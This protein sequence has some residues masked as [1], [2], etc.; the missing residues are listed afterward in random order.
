MGRGEVN[1]LHIEDKHICLQLSSS[2]KSTVGARQEKGWRRDFLTIRHSYQ[3][4]PLS[5]SALRKEAFATPL[6]I[7]PTHHSPSYTLVLP[8]SLVTSLVP[9]R[10]VPL[11]SYETRR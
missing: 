9:V 3:P 11:A 6:L 10:S 1:A 7:D 2:S 4:L 8:H 5:S